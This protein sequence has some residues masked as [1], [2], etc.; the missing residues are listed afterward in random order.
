[1]V[2]GKKC[3][4]SVHICMIN[5]HMVFISVKARPQPRKQKGFRMEKLQEFLKVAR[6]FGEE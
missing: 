1:M 5:V 4:F 6:R 2:F 3:M